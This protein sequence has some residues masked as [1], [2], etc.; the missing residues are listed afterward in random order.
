MVLFGENGC[1]LKKW[2]W[3][4]KNWLYLG[5]VFAFAKNDFAWGILPYFGKSGCVLKMIMVVFG[6]NL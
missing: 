5:T 6:K 4:G 2:L 1:I 3:L